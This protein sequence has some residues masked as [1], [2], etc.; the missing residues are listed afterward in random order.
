MSYIKRSTIQ[1]L[2]FP[3]SFFLL[4]VFLYA[5]AF[6]TSINL[7]KALLIGFILHVLVYP[8]SN[9][10][11]SFMD[12]DIAS[13]GGVKQ[14][15]LPEKQLLYVTILFD[16]VALLLSAMI[17]MSYFILIGIYITCSRL[18][19]YRGV[20]LKKYPIIGYIIVVANQGCLIF[21]AVYSELNLESRSLP[22]SL[23][24]INAGLLIGAFYPLTQIYQHQQDKYDD[25]KT[26]SM[27][28]G[29]RGTFIF[30]AILNILSFII[31]YFILI[32]FKLNYFIFSLFYLPAVFYFVKWAYACFQ[33]PSAANF[34]KTMRMNYW[35]MTSS[36]A[37]FLFILLIKHFG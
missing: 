37:S 36:I 27:A 25:V 29:I 14:P 32:E 21:Y 7:Y 17:S 24:L 26:I 5:L 12:R 19:S 22:N 11:N 23:M 2:R 6:S 18:Y 13:I 31:Y 28:L 20:R 16:L 33:N 34:D 8:S 35:A 10:Y 3:F 1:L 4:P 30:S 15:M 9:G